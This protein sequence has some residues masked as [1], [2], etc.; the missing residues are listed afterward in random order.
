MAIARGNRIEIEALINRSLR[1]M[2]FSEMFH[3]FYYLSIHGLV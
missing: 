2:I 3:T 1:F